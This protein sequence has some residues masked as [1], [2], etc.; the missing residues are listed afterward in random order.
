MML[1]AVTDFPEPDSP[2]IPSVSPFFKRNDNLF[3]ARY[4][5][6]SV[7]KS[8]QKSFISKIIAWMS[9]PQFSYSSSS[10]SSVILSSGL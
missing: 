7:L 10:S 2:T 6:F 4:M 9:C 5:P 1:K 8:T 3:T